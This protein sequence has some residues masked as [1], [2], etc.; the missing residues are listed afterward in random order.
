MNT[1]EQLNVAIIS[2]EDRYL[3]DFVNLNLAWLEY[4]FEVE[5]EDKILMSQA[6]E[7]IIDTGGEIFFAKVGEEIV[8]TVAMIDRGENGFELAKMGVTPKYQGLK[9]GQKLLD[10]CLD[11]ARQKGLDRVYL[12]SNTRMAPAINLYRKNGFVEL[13]EYKPSPYKRSNIQ[14]EIYL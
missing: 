12:E 11:F 2:F 9:I 13:K 14:M 6:K 5:E 8:G 7:R 1:M 4:F 10:A 3:Q